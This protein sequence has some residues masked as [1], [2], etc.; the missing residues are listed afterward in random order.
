[1]YKTR[2]FA[3]PKICFSFV[4]IFFLLNKHYRFHNVCYEIMHIR[5]GREILYDF[6]LVYINILQRKISSTGPCI[7]KTQFYTKLQICS[8]TLALFH[9]CAIGSFTDTSLPPAT[10]L[11][12][13]IKY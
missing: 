8:S 1:M 9:V 2:Y 5:M 10:L 6:V 7:N 4:V 3:K 13:K 11:K 12:Y